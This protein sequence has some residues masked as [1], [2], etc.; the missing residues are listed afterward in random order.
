MAVFRPQVRG[1]WLLSLI[2]LAF[3]S[4]CDEATETCAATRQSCGGRS[5]VLG[6]GLAGLVAAQTLRRAGCE[7]VVLEAQPELG[8]RA[9]ALPTGPFRGLPK[10]AQ[11]IHG[12]ER[13]LPMM[14]L[15]H[16]YNLSYTRVGGNTD[17]EGDDERHHLIHHGLNASLKAEAFRLFGAAHARFEREALRRLAGGIYFDNVN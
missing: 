12:G 5:I 9:K 6:A 15:L 7:V 16:F 10:G 4:T 8:G 11:W 2:I 3:G 14:A 1:P 13:N 17:F